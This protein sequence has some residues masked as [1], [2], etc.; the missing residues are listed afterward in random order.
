[1]KTT[2]TATTTTTITGTG[3]LHLR[4]FVCLKS[5]NILW[6]QPA[7]LPM[8]RTLNYRAFLKKKI[9]G[10]L[11]PVRLIEYLDLMLIDRQRHF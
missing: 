1:M 9:L 5:F 2:T 3:I 8:Q 11:V 7:A 6:Q 4:R 10:R